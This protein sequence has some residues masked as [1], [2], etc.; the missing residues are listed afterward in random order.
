[1]KTIE[2]NDLYYPVHVLQW[3]V[4]NVLYNT[5]VLPPCGS[6][7]TKSNYHISFKFSLVVSCN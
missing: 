5:Q 2:D 6:M 3:S 7:R 4:N 1:M